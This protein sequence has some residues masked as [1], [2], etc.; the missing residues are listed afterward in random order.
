MKIFTPTIHRP[1]HMPYSQ[2]SPVSPS[3]MVFSFPLESSIHAERVGRSVRWKHGSFKTSP[4]AQEAVQYSRFSSPRVKMN[5]PQGWECGIFSL[6]SNTN[7]SNT[8]ANVWLSDDALHHDADRDTL[9]SHPHPVFW[10]GLPQ[11]GGFS[12][13]SRWK[14][15]GHR[16]R[17]MG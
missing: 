4:R 17:R 5:H 7:D 11:D 12:L 3:T 8:R 16:G 2:F 14:V 15:L 9:L 10:H 13:G 1:L 6:P